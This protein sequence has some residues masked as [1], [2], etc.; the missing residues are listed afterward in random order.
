M[1]APVRT[2]WWCKSRQ[3]IT[4]ILSFQR[5]FLLLITYDVPFHQ[6]AVDLSSG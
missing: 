2:V 1:F 3:W 6:I 5:V 4:W